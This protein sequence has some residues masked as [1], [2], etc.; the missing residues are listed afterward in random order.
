MS[1]QVFT[2]FDRRAALLQKKTTSSCDFSSA[3][4][5]PSSFVLRPP[6]SSFSPPPIHVRLFSAIEGRHDISSTVNHRGDA[7]TEETGE[8]L[9]GSL[10]RRHNGTQ[11]AGGP[12]C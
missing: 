4:F 9:Q 10:R 11:S 1:H 7:R 8:T 12:Q 3:S 6:S 2:W 5:P